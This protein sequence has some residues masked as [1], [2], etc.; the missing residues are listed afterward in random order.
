[1]SNSDNEGKG[2]SKRARLTNALDIAKMKVDRLMERVDK[3]IILQS[4][5]NKEAKVRA[6]TEFVR[7]VQGS[8]AGAGSG[9]FH[10]YRN[11]RR[12]EFA[13]LKA[14]DVKD[15]MEKDKSEYEQRIE[16]VR[17]AEEQKTA[18][19]RQKRRKRNVK[20]KKGAGKNA[21]AE[22]GSESE[23]GEKDK[24]DEGSEEEDNNDAD[25][26]LQKGEEMEK[27]RTSDEDK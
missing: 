10:V 24:K 8:S 2:P 13:R 17:L 16:A 11:L 1:M 15:K 7:N 26:S 12:K 5:R 6:P 23:K 4:R 22:S 9:E 25:E 27:E 18:K 21:D 19:R 3:P 20:G 14:M